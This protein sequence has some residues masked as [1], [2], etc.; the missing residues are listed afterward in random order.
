[1]R[2]EQYKKMNSRQSK[3]SIFPIYFLVSFLIL[4]FLVLVIQRPLP[5]QDHFRTGFMTSN[6]LQTELTAAKLSHA[7]SKPAYDLG[8]FGNSRSVMVSSTHLQAPEMSFFNFSVPG[9]SIRQSIVMLEELARQNKLPRLSII[10][11]DNAHLQFYGNA[12]LRRPALQLQL[13]VQDVFAEGVSLKERA[14]MLWRHVY[15]VGWVGVL[16]YFNWLEF[17]KGLAFQRYGWNEPQVGVGY[18]ADGSRPQVG[19]DDTAA[20]ALNVNVPSPSVLRGYLIKDLERVAR[21][22]RQ[23]AA[24]II[25][26]ESPLAPQSRL[27]GGADHPVAISTRRT[28]LQACRALKLT[29]IPAAKQHP[30]LVSPDWQDATH[31]PASSLGAFLSSLVKQKAK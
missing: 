28:F 10:S 16:R 8:L 4:F 17:Q 6:I 11:F 2:F 14:R 18:L 21:L 26:Y 20:N 9:A 1:M 5:N 23:G 3:Q 31:A 22:A 29:C 30:A 7:S 15:Q 25:V 13:A 12:E 19:I 24:Q 27:L